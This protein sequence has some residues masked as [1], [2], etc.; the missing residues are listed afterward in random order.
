M[1]KKVK[2]ERVYQKVIEQ[3]GEMIKEGYLKKGDKLPPERE[4]VEQ[5]GV[6]RTSIREALRVLEILGIVE[7]RQG[8]GN[9]I[10]EHL[11]DAFFQPI[12]L[13]FMLRNSEPME[14]LEMRRIMDVG[15]AGLAAQR[16]SEDSLDKL[17][18]IIEKFKATED[19]NINANLDKDFHYIIVEASGNSLARDL[20]KTISLLFDKFITGARKEIMRD[21]KNQLILLSQHEEIYNAMANHDPKMAEEAMKKHLEFVNDFIVR[22][23]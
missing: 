11:E 12:S 14:I 10:S 4:L 7:S 23:Y 16:I 8:E 15:I 5:L 19:E 3:I 21:K 2:I 17:K 9:F 1:F 20:Y 6:S 13:M 22:H 18:E